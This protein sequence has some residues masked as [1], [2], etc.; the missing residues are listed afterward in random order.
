MAAA[1]TFCGGIA[2]EFYNQAGQANFKPSAAEAL[3]RRMLSAADVEVHTLCH[4][5]TVNKSEGRDPVNRN[6]RW[7]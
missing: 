7:P 1:K 4:L 3:Y 2:R 5:K 6:G